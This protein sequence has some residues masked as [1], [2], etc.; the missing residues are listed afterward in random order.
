MDY[1]LWD[2]NLSLIAFQVH[3]NACGGGSGHIRGARCRKNIILNYRTKSGNSRFSWFLHH[4][5]HLFRVRGLSGEGLV[6]VV[7][8]EMGP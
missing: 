5:Y 4:C 1:P 6:F 7:T 8:G 2:A 3:R